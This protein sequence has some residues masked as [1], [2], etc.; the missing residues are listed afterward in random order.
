MKHPLPSAISSTLLVALLSACSGDDLSMLAADP[1][2]AD[3][4]E[5]ATESAPLTLDASEQTEQEL[6][7]VRWE[8]VSGDTGRVATGLDAEG[9]TLAR[10]A[11]HMS[12]ASAQ[13]GIEFRT[14]E[15][16]FHSVKLSRDGRVLHSDSDDLLALAEALFRDGSTPTLP[17][18]VAPQAGAEIGVARQALVSTVGYD[19]GMMPPGGGCQ[20]QTSGVFFGN[21]RGYVS[22]GTWV[23]SHYA[24]S[25]CWAQVSIEYK[26]TNGA[27]IQG[28]IYGAMACGTWDPTCSSFRYTATPQNDVDLQGLEIQ[29]VLVHQ[30]F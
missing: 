19:T 22:G 16:S 15:P 13:D 24:F 28:P 12:S 3:P 14:L 10:L 30:T 5:A 18:T 27:S 26:A 23:Q 2:P 21:E 20:A 1:L 11:I 25:G 9:Q 6:G 8:A 4:V 29:D 7:I 17:T